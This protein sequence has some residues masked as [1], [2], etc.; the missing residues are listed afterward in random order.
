MGRIWDDVESD[1][2]TGWEK[3]EGKSNSTWENVK[4]AVRDA[5]HRVTG[6][7]DLD[8]S[9]MREASTDRF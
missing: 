6:Q 2:K 4:H 1:L 3:F 5:W 7:R 8:T 9:K